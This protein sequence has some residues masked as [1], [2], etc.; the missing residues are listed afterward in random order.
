MCLLS[1]LRSRSKVRF[2]LLLHAL[3]GHLGTP[4][5]RRGEVER[6]AFHPHLQ[7]LG[8]SAE[9][10]DEFAILFRAD[11]RLSKNAFGDTILCQDVDSTS[12]A[13]GNLSLCTVGLEGDGQPPGRAA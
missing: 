4:L 1:T 12:I 8:A 10:G 2:A 3:K 11:Q 6:I 9:I 5:S 13:F 7:F